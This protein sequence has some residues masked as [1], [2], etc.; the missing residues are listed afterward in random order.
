MSNRPKFKSQY[1]N[2]IGGEWVAPVDGEYFENKSPVDGS[3][4]ASVPKSNKNDI[5]L[6]V[7]AAWKAAPT[8]N[9]SSATERSTL[10]NKI[11]DRIEENLEK[12][13]LVET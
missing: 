13:A 4:I 8:W 7:K 5:D 11:A 6:A 10:L 12:L 3:V 1:E 2:Y 9:K